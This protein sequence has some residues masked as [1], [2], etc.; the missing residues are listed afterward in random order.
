MDIRKDTN[1]WLSPSNVNDDLYRHQSLYMPGSCD[2]IIND[3]I[4][5]QFMNAN[6]DR[7]L[8]IQGRPGSGKSTAAAFTIKHLITNTKDPVLYFFC[9]ASDAERTLPLHILRTLLWQLLDYD[10]SLYA[11][12]IPWQH[13]N[14][15]P[16]A[17]SEFDVRAMFEMAFSATRK[18]P[19]YLV[20]DALDECENPPDLLRALFQGPLV[21]SK[22]LKIILLSR[23]DPALD[24]M[25]EFSKAHLSLNSNS[26]PVDDYIRERVS[27]IGMFANQDL[28]QKVTISVIDASE[29]LWL[30]AR[31]LLDEIERAPSFTE[32]QRQIDSVP[33]GLKQLYTSIISAKE[34]RQSELQIRMAQQ[35][36]LWLDTS[37]YVPEWLWKETNGD[38]LEDDMITNLLQYASSSQQIFSPLKIVRELCAPL[39]EARVMFPVPV[40]LN[41]VPHDDMIFT[42]EFFHQTA[43]NY[44][45]WTTEAPLLQLPTSLK[46][47]RL[48]DLHR[49]VTAAWYFSECADFQYSLQQLRE[50]PRSGRFHCYFEMACGLW[51]SLKI[52]NIR[53]DLHSEE[54]YQVEDMCDQMTW[55]LTTDKC[56]PFLEVSIIIHFAEKSTLLLDNTEEA[57]KISSSKDHWTSI[58]AF[59]RFQ[60][61]RQ[62]FMG[63]LAYTL[64]SLW[65][66]FDLPDYWATRYGEKPEGF[67]DRALARKILALATRYQSLL[68]TPGARSNNCFTVSSRD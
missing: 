53:R 33:H 60:H 1:R 32:V 20:I 68:L 10:D 30:F 57:L 24:K 62:T 5:Q 39:I 9:K 12:L 8:R 43:K 2:W 4:F 15:R 65:P 3:P 52:K 48:G 34:P 49:G 50:R 6:D 58:P 22:S 13:R 19:I 14:G 18:S 38:S 46:P 29:G 59:R 44:L 41:G 40:S 21:I 64:V 31:L 16:M 11:L 47:K 54:Q 7:T 17:D 36:Y 28:C 67:N 51:G 35:L 23:D 25:L 56:L 26:Q 27:K 42:V 63:D 66:K 61:A 45:K 55:F 37:E